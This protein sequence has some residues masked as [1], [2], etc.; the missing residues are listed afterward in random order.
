MLVLSC[1][2]GAV[3]PSPPVSA[4]VAITMAVN[5]AS[6]T[7]TALDETTRFTAEVR[8]Q[9]GQVMAG[10]AVAWASSDAS[11]AS[12]DASGLVT[13]VANG[14]AT[15]TATAGSASGSARGTARITVDA[16]PHAPPYHG[17][18]FLDADIIAPSDPT[19]FVGL[20][21]AG[22]GERLVYDRRGEAWIT[23]RAY[24]FNATFRSGLSAEFQVNPEFGTWTEAEAAARDYAPAIGQIPV[25][26]RAD[27]DAV[28]IHRGDEPFGGGNRSLLV[29]TGRGE[30]LRQQ[31]FLPEVSCT[32][33]SIRRSIRHMRT[34]PAGW[35]HRRLTPRPSRPMRGITRIARTWPRASVL[36]GCQAPQ[37]P[38]HRRH[39]RHDHLGDSQPPRLFRQPGP[40][41]LPRCHGRGVRGPGAVDAVGHR[42]SRMGRPGVGSSVANP[43]GRVVGAV[44]EVVDGPDAGRQVTTDD[45]G[46][47]LLESLEEAQF[48][49]PQTA[50]RLPRHGSRMAP[51]AVLRLSAR[52]SRRQR[53]R[54]LRHQPDLQRG[55]RGASEP[56]VG[57]LRC[58]LRQEPRRLR[59]C[60]LHIGFDRL[61]ESRAALSDDLHPGA[62]NVTTCYLDYPRWFIM[63]YQIRTWA[64]SCMR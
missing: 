8:A 37:R 43:G 39:G 31:G 28:W 18:V 63:P 14:G 26:L 57:L 4:P 61:Q 45:L 13:A 24:L 59:R 27:M 21:P 10:T 55:P 54:V 35:R 44:V 51:D 30:E 20:E 48:T 56:R 33:A 23:I 53:A 22:R 34:R 5:P 46:Q 17:T 49:A 15:I 42:Q 1:G 64:P 7:L 16:P 32:R 19:D 6:A 2:D 3:E 29:H 62:R 40:Q 9:D 38:H 12:V 11:V 58:P 47:Y 36:A 52:A 50:R 60:L 25:A 41:P